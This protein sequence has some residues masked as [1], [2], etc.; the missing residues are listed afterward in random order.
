MKVSQVG[1]TPVGFRKSRHLFLVGA[2]AEEVWCLGKCR[3]GNR[4]RPWWCLRLCLRRDRRRL[5]RG[6]RRWRVRR[7]RNMR[8]SLMWMWMTRVYLEDSN[9]K[10]ERKEGPRVVWFS[11]KSTL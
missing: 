11:E 2:G 8:V 5:V 3:G 10:N 1:K 4:I 6:L 7:V 9:R